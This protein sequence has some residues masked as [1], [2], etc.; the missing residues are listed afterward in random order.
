MADRE[1]R[2]EV[3]VRVTDWPQHVPVYDSEDKPRTAQDYAESALAA[4]SLSEASR[5]DGYADLPPS[6]YPNPGGGPDAAIVDVM[7]TEVIE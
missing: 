1:F 6:T 7:F 2:F 3:T 4:A 5:L